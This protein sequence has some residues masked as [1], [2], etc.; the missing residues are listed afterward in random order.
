MDTNGKQRGYSYVFVAKSVFLELFGTLSGERFASNRS[1]NAIFAPA[2]PA[3]LRSRFCGAHSRH[4]T[5]GKPSQA[6]GARPELRGLAWARYFAEALSVKGGF[7][8][9]TSRSGG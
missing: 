1:F 3:K 8:P 9:S 2:Q 4:L 7:G 6:G 5:R